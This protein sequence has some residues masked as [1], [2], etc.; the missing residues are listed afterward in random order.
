MAEE[1]LGIDFEIHGGGSDLIFP[2]HE[3]EAAQ[4]R[5]R[6]APS[7]RGSGC[8]TACC[9]LDGEKMSKSVGNM[10]PLHEALDD[11]AATR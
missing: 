3:N 9:E 2:H 5:A 4:T 8:T 10:F 1:L 6:A 7:S 11:T